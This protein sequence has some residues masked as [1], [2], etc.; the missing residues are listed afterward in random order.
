[1]SLFF[2]G[3]F[4]TVLD[5]ADMSRTIEKVMRGFTRRLDRYVDLEMTAC[6]HDEPMVK[7]GRARDRLLDFV[8]EEMEYP[9]TYEQKKPTEPGWYWCFNDG[10]NPGEKWE[11]VVRLD[12]Q[13]SGGDLVCSWM[14]APGAAA[15]MIAANWSEKCLW[16]GPIPT[17]RL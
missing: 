11:A 13:A 10:D 3:L 8:R 4:G 1:M 15:I 16:A 5:T 17:P 7:A 2:S 9:F 6:G 12:R 14:T